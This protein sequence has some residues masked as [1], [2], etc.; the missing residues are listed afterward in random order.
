MGSTIDFDYVFA[1]LDNILSLPLRKRGRRWCM[2]ARINLESHRRHD[3]TVFYMNKSGT[4]TVTEQGGDSMNLFDFLI[5][6]SPDCH[7]PRD[8]FNKLSDPT[9]CRISVNDFYNGDWKENVKDPRHVDKKYVERI[10]D[11]EH[12]Q[13]NNL[14]SYLCS[15]FPSDSVSRVF[16]LY[17]VGCLGN[18][19]V[20]YW[21]SDSDGNICHDNRIQYAENGHRIKDTHAYRKFKTGDGFLYKGYFKPFLGTLPAEPIKCMVESEKT[22]LIAS[23]TVGRGFVWYACG[24]MNQ[25]GHDLPKN[26]L[27]F[28]DYDDKA[29]DYWKRSGRVVEWWKDEVLREGLEHNDDIGD[30]LIRWKDK[31]DVKLLIK[32]IYT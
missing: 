19:Q 9:N 29:I 7:C 2:P 10:S 14:Y 3:K 28:P 12:W 8:V 13:G 32:L 22:A 20:V 17:K 27:L 23:L 26:V 31:Y 24:G 5:Q 30:A 6:Y 18:R 16:G 21:F 1:N 4:I 11:L 25:L 15:Q